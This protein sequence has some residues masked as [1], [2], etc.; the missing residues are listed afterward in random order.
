MI[1]CCKAVY[2]PITTRSSR[3][4]VRPISTKSRSTRPSAPSP[5]NNATDTCR[6]RSRLAAHPYLRD[7]RRGRRL[8]DGFAAGEHTRVCPAAAA[9]LGVPGRHAAGLCDSDTD[10]EDLVHSPIWRMMAESRRVKACTLHSPA[11]HFASPRATHLAS[12]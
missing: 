5:T 6:W 1:P 3:G 2:Y 12:D 8:A 11:L 4:W 7:H 9:L 10:G